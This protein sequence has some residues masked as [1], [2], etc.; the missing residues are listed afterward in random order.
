MD[1]DKLLSQVTK[2]TMLL[3]RSFMKMSHMKKLESLISDCL[4]RY[5]DLFFTKFNNSISKVK[6]FMTHDE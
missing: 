5:V 2:I 1:M 3:Q 6:E 4:K